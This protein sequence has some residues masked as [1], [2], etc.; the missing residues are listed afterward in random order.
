MSSRSAGH[1]P[2]RAQG[3]RSTLCRVLPA[4]GSRLF[5]SFRRR[6]SVRSGGARQERRTT[7]CYASQD[8]IDRHERDDGI[9]SDERAEFARLRRENLKLRQER[10]LL[11]RAAAFF[12]TENG[13]R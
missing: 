4:V 2:A 5:E 11:K 12:A 9:T 1:Q 10:D 8:Q 6:R 3:R 13:T 7:A